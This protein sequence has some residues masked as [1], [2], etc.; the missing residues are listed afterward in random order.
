MEGILKGIQSGIEFIKGS[1]KEE[2]TDDED[3]EE[4][5][6]RIQMER[7]ASKGMAFQDENIESELEKNLISYETLEDG[8]TKVTNRGTGKDIL[9]IKRESDFYMYLED[10]REYSK[11][12]SKGVENIKIFSYEEFK[13][14]GYELIEE[15][16]SI[17]LLEAIEESEEE[18]DD[19][20]AAEYDNHSSDEEVY[21]PEQTLD[22]DDDEE[23]SK[24]FERAQ[25]DLNGITIEPVPEV[26]ETNILT[27]TPLTKT[28]RS[29]RKG[30]EI[31]H[32]WDVVQGEL[33]ERENKP[34]TSDN[35]NNN[36]NVPQNTD[37]KPQKKAFENM[38]FILDTALY[39]SYKYDKE[40][41]KVYN[42]PFAKLQD[43]VI[44]E[45]SQK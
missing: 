40:L 41:R 42:I 4:N 14:D 38:F 21:F 7:Q 6:L 37:N 3:D 33:S 30:G 25:P 36:N 22:I 28:I 44:S 27:Q 20:D 15:K 18:D 32:M 9:F 10:L 12:S 24:V 39:E 31:K 23:I 2:P 13:K 5:E 43:L 35:N 26:S 19:D 1:F 16:Q 29:R 17:G 45:I 11:R 34:I 8:V